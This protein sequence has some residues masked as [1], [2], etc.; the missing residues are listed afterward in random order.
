MRSGILR[1]ADCLLVE[2]NALV[3]GFAGSHGSEPL[4]EGVVHAGRRGSGEPRGLALPCG[5]RFA[6]AGARGLCR[7]EERTSLLRG[8]V[9]PRGLAHPEHCAGLVPLGRFEEAIEV[10]KERRIVR[11]EHTRALEREDRVVDLPC[12]LR[13]R[14]N[15]AERHQLFARIVDR[16]QRCLARA[17]RVAVS[18]LGVVETCELFAHAQVD[19]RRRRSTAVRALEDLHDPDAIGPGAP[20]RKRGIELEPRG[21]GL[22]RLEAGL[23]LEQARESRVI[24]VTHRVIDE[25]RSHRADPGREIERTHERRARAGH[26]AEPAVEEERALDV[27][28]RRRLVVL[29]QL[30]QPGQQLGELGVASRTVERRLRAVDRAGVIGDEGERVVP[31]RHRLARHAITRLE[32]ARTLAQP[33]GTRTLARRVG[34]ELVDVRELRIDL[35]SAEEQ[36]AQHRVRRRR[37]LA[38]LRRRLRL[39]ERGARLT[40]REHRGRELEPSAELADRVSAPRGDERPQA[41]ELR[42]LRIER[43]AVVDLLRPREACARPVERRR[44]DTVGAGQ[45]RDVLRARGSGDDRSSILVDLDEVIRAQLDD[46]TR[47]RPWPGSTHGPQGNT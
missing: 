36:R 26:V 11:L 10:A 3:D 30:R 21:A 4:R 15:R 16:P 2:A 32:E 24:T 19:E 37:M 18:T 6:T 42:I 22:V 35:L 8:L 12:P 29:H 33:V 25:R 40:A 14:D 13:R 17:Q 23:G 47:Q 1:R 45:H 5:V 38:D 46:G 20:M 27:E 34:H 44:D 7:D 28:P 9:D 41:T 31:R 43:R 39:G